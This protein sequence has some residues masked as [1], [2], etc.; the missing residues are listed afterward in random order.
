MFGHNLPTSTDGKGGQ[1]DAI[2]HINY[3]LM[4]SV[5]NKMTSCKL[6]NSISLND[7]KYLLSGS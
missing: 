7:Y 6:L 1:S 4:R 2:E 3:F 5:L